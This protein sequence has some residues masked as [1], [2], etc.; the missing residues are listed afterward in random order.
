MIDVIR[1][2]V[3]VTRPPGPH[4]GQPPPPMTHPPK[5]SC[6]IERRHSNTQPFTLIDI[7]PRQY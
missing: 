1:P 7:I 5:L 4:T 3:A 6:Q 2:H